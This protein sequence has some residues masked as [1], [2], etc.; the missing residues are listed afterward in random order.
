MGDVLLTGPAVRALAA[1]GRG[2]SFLAGPDGAE[3]AG[4]LPGVTE[5]L[6]WRVPWIDATPVPV[7]HAALGKVTR[8]LRRRRFS[9]AVIFTSF[10][11]SPLPTALVLR[12]AGVAR[13][14]AISS[15]Y[16]GSLLDV[17]H[18]VDEDL[19]EAD[20]NMS[21]VH[22]AGFE[23]PSG[24]DGLLAIRGPLPDARRLAGREPYVVVHPTA[25]VPARAPSP[26]RC[27]AIV[28]A[29]SKAGHRV[30]VTGTN[31]DRAVTAQVSDD[32]AVDLGGRT[33][34]PM[35]AAVLAGADVVVA[36][37]TGAAHLAAAVGTPVV[38][39]FAPVVPLARWRPHRV[40]TIVL[41]DQ[42]AACAG[43][44][45]RI[46]PV[47]GHPCLNLIDA[48]EVVTAVATLSRRQRP[49]PSPP[50]HTVRGRQRPIPSPPAHT[51]VGVTA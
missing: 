49:I 9:E 31:A 14:S 28:K 47:A 39:L 18:Q 33:T 24:D 42:D 27:A 44:R 36:P 11:Q 40:P 41:G 1:A 3:A 8:I 6:T 4:L 12:V 38:S 13:I 50:A 29:L 35:L 48:A 32:V 15:D 43:S 20:R 46:C 37:N 51:A 19:P 5:V 34:R 30:V 10:H 26:G 23:L 25:S 16:P 17:R 22:A 2:V 21:L 7:G 45:A